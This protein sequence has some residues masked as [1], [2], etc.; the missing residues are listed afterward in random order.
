MAS[1]KSDPGLETSKYPLKYMMEAQFFGYEKHMTDDI[2]SFVCIRAPV[3]KTAS[4]VSFTANVDFDDYFHFQE[5]IT[6]NE[7]P[8]ALI[9]CWLVKNEDI[10]GQRFPPKVEDVFEKNYKILAANPVEPIQ[11]RA[12]YVLANLI[13]VHPVLLYLQGTNGFNQILENLTAL[14]ALKKYES[15]LTESFGDGAFQFE[16]VGES[17]EQND[18]KYEQILT[19]NSTDLMIPNILINSYKLWHKFGYYFFDDFRFDKSMKKDICGY[20]INLG[21]KNQFK[22]NDMYPK[23]E[24]GDIGMGLKLIEKSPL[25]DPFGALYQ[26]DPSIIT[27]SYEMQF[28]FRKT[29]QKRQV[30]QITTD[31]QT[32]NRGSKDGTA[33]VRSKMSIKEAEPNEETLIYAPDNHVNA[34]NRFDKTSQQLRDDIL[35]VE[36]YFVRDTSLDCIQFGKR[37]NLDPGM[38]NFYDHIPISICN[39]FTRD[40]GQVPILVHNM[41]FQSLRYRPDVAPGRINEDQY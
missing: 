28:G 33:I 31:V 19:R 23:G 10:H 14:D 39:M 35:C 8:D 30:P 34:L 6:R 12:P 7:Y 41:K 36:T 24:S 4:F 27:K 29:T 16:K 9:K 17:Y 3:T 21:D 13:L 18:W 26:K 32:G 5:H 38:T 1:E 11:P 40:S 15:W 20:L 22:Q 37:Y 2:S 25:H